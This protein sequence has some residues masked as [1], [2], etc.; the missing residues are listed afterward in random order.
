MYLRLLPRNRV[1]N[2][3]QRHVN[4][5]PV[6]LQRA[7]NDHHKQH[8]DF[9]FCTA[10]IRNLEEISSF[11]GPK[12]VIFMSRDDKVPRTA[13][14]HAKDFEQILEDNRFATY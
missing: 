8:A 4:Y 10:T 2:E 13:H 14:S 5:V 6:R 11:L 3:G 12:Q 7:T 1:T 9:K